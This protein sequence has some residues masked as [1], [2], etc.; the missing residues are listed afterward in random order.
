[1]P[2]WS[3]DLRAGID[4]STAEV[5]DHIK[6]IIVQEIKRCA[7]GLELF[8]AHEKRLARQL[9]KDGPFAPLLRALSRLQSAKEGGKPP[10]R[11]A[12]VTARGRAAANHICVRSTHREKNGSNHVRTSEPLLL[13]PAM[14][15]ERLER[16]TCRVLML[17][18]MTNHCHLVC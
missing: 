16:G 10:V 3:D 5:I 11:V 8:N 15:A 1:V 2:I 13:E 18:L 6:Q 17:C 7:T 14:M 12:L 9:L 4:A